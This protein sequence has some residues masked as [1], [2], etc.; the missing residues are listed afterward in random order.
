M[1]R[2]RTV[3]EIFDERGPCQLMALVVQLAEKHKRIPVGHWNIDLLD[4]WHLEM[5]GTREPIGHI[6]A[7]HGLMTQD[8]LPVVMFNAVGGT[9]LGLDAE[10]DAIE[11]LQIALDAPQTKAGT[12]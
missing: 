9:S 12:P 8:G 11:A 2:Q 3:G 4:G 6:P 7:F 1:S 5:N 10:D